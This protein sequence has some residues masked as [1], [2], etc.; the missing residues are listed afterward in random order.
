MKLMTK[1]LLAKFRSTGSQEESPDPIIICKFF[2]P[3]GTGTWYA[4][5]FDE[6]T[7]IFFWYV[8]IFWDECDEWGN[9]SLKELKEFRGGLGLWIERDLHFPLCKFSER[10]N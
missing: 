10:K 1:E 4:T 2:N 3:T 6:E 7:G 8:S 5:E 9:F